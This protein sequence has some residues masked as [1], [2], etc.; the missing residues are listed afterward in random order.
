[1][2]GLLRQWARRAAVGTALGMGM[3]ACAL[4]G[5]VA[6]ANPPGTQPVVLPTGTPLRLQ[7]ETAISSDDSKP[8][9]GFAARVMQT[10]YVGDRRAIPA[11]SILE[12]RIVQIHDSSPILGHSELM[13]RPDL[14]TTPDGHQYTISATVSSTDA[15]S[16]TTVGSEGMIVNS[17]APSYANKASGLAGGVG[18]AIVGGMM[19]GARG[20]VVGGGAGIAI[21]AG[22]WLLHR[23]HTSLFAGSEMVVSLDRPLTVAPSSA[24]S[25]E[26]V[27]P[28]TPPPAVS[29]QAAALPTTEA[30]RGNSADQTTG[31]DTISTGNE[32]TIPTARDAAKANLH[33]SDIEAPQSSGPSLTKPQPNGRARGTA[34]VPSDDVD[35]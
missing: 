18:S 27:S 28:I 11:G 19:A 3:V 25:N 4:V 9:D 10:I 23:R 15:L 12:G 33:A 14:L 7:L 20:A 13:L 5:D 1:M 21:S 16:G 8:G 6:A 17:R 35:N 30:K 34:P 22:W 29:G 24:R 2:N 26:A 32:A 31:S